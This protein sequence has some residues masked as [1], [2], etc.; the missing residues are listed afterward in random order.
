MMYRVNDFENEAT[1]FVQDQA[2]ADELNSNPFISNKCFVGGKQDAE[3]L[4]A[5]NQQRALQQEADRFSISASFINGDKVDWRVLEAS[6]PEDTVCQVFDTFAGQYIQCANKTEAYALN[7]AKKQQFLANIGL[8][9]VIE[10]DV[11]PAKAKAT[12]FKNNNKIPVEVM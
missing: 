3:A 11:A 4:L 1:Y 12:I 7:E 8:D 5:Q 2:T 10:L 9:K 6:D